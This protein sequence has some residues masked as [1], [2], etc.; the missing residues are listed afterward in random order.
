MILRSLSYKI[1]YLSTFS[2]FYFFL[3]IISVVVFSNI[4]YSQKFED[5]EIK[6]AKLSDNVY[7]ITGKGGNLGLLI[8]KD[9]Y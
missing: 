2:L 5:V 3:F 7:V 4:S 6:S 8:G 1:K 9:G